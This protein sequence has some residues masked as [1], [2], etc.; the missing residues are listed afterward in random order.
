ML[1]SWLLAKAFAVR[2]Q[3]DGQAVIV[4]G[5]ASDWDAAV[6]A[7]VAAVGGGTGVGLGREVGVG[8]DVGVP[9]GKMVKGPP[10]ESPPWADGAPE[11]EPGRWRSALERSAAER[12]AN[13]SRT[14]GTITKRA[15]RPVRRRL[16]RF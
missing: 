16:S 9:V 13:N 10:A 8:L 15:R 14:T 5:E 4:P 11:A 2:L 7:I 12:Q 6:N 1:K 3:L